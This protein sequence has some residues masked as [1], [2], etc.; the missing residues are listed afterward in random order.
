MPTRALRGAI[1]VE[2]DTR[3]AILEAARELLEALIAANDLAPEHVISAI[4]TATPDLTAA[5]PAPAARELGWTRAGL[6]C[7]QEMSIPAGLPRCL[8][9]LIH[10]ESALPQ[11][12]M[13]HRYLRAAA[14]LRPDLT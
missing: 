1:T 12:A 5:H 10:C 4:F 3:A 8:R 7:V 6:M 13:R 11:S 2:A 14:A 9:V